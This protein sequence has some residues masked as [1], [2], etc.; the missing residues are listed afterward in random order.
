MRPGS[1]NWDAI[2]AEYITSGISLRKLSEE[3]GIT[4]RRIAMKSKEEEWVKLRGEYRNKVSTKFQQKSQGKDVNKLAGL[5]DATELAIDRVMKILQDEKQFHRHIVYESPLP[6][7]SEA[8]EKICDKA[9]TKALKDVVNTLKELTGMM[10]DF[11]NI[12]TPA[13]AEAQ[14]IAAERLALEQKR[15]DADQV[16]KDIHVVIGGDAEDY[17]V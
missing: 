9:D 13:Q 14:R 17:S 2:K 4:T 7:T 16:D 15:A 8:V 10:R 12:P 5:T 1:T 6:G 11:Y 3:H